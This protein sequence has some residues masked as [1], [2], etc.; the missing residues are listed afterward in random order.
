MRYTPRLSTLE[1]PIMRP[2][3]VYASL[4]TAFVLT[5]CGDG[6]NGATASSAAAGARM[7]AAV[8]QSAQPVIFSGVVANY[9]V[10][11][12]DAGYV[13]TD[14]TGA[15]VTRV[16]AATAR[17]RFA[18]VSLA[19]DADGNPGQ[20]Y[21]LYRA[22]FAREPDA[23]GLGYWMAVLDQGSSL[24][25]MAAGFTASAEFKTLYA[26]AKTNRDI[27]SQY[28]L[29][30]LKRPGE[31]AGLDYW[32]GVLDKNQDS[33]AGVLRNFSEGDENKAGTAAAIAAGIRYIEYGVRYPATAYPVRAA[34]MQNIAAARTDYQ[35]VTGSCPGYSS[36]T[37]SAP[38]GATFEGQAAQAAQNDI[39][40][41]LTNCN[42]TAFAWSV[43]DYYDANG[44]LLGTSMPQVEYDV[45]GGILPATAKVG[46]Q[47]VYATQTVYADSS[48]QSTKGTRTLGYAVN[49]DGDS[50]N[51]VILTLTDTHLTAANQASEIRTS[52]Y[53][54]GIDGSLQPLSVDE[55]YSGGAHF[56]Y[57]QTPASAQPAALTIT[58]TVAGS[59]AAAQNG[60]TLTVNYTGWLYVPNAP[61]FKGQQF[62][63]STGRG[64]FSFVL[65][66]GKVIKGWDQGMLGMKV[67][68][69]RTLLIP[70]NLG[71][72]T[73]GQAG[74]IITGNAPLVFE[75]ELVSV[76]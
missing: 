48:K 23:A 37:Y 75:V 16:V 17:L 21:R 44:A 61:G 36:F 26:N 33:L 10:T 38:T 62:D 66:A 34:Y 49:A 55:Q 42:A 65:G 15:E 59:G 22:A 57:V 52:R 7:G 53:R 58:D 30:V 3:L 45:G 4:L 68:G 20:A 71:Y 18:D 73:A 19:F 74:T 40:L 14:T 11:K 67:G 41:G 32:T 25:D 5:G 27:V 64:A 54:L 6:Q 47:G 76:K 56:I 9:T 2:T 72:N 69:K 39:S 1:S 29:N 43:I 35:T 50:A 28:Y 24:L 12:T 13:I 46:D 60:Q 51:S 8:P 70:S 63:S 31:S